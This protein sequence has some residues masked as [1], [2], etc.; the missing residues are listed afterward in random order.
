MAKKKGKKQKGE[1]EPPDPRLSAMKTIISKETNTRKEGEIT[2]NKAMMP[3]KRVNSNP[4]IYEMIP[5][6]KSLFPNSK[7]VDF[8]FEGVLDIPN[9]V[10]YKEEMDDVTV[11]LGDLPPLNMKKGANLKTSLSFLNS[12]EIDSR[13][14]DQL[15]KVESH[16][17]MHF[18]KT[19]VGK[20][21]FENILET[22]K[23]PLVD[24]QKRA[25]DEGGFGNTET[26]KRTARCCRLLI[27]IVFLLLILICGTLIGLVFAGIP[28]PYLSDLV[29]PPEPVS[30]ITD[31]TTIADVVESTTPLPESYI[32]VGSGINSGQLFFVAETELFVIQANVFKINNEAVDLSWEY[33][34]PPEHSKSKLLEDVFID[35]YD[36]LGYKIDIVTVDDINPGGSSWK[37]QVRPFGR[38]KYNLDIMKWYGFEYKG[39]ETQDEDYLEKTTKYVEEVFLSQQNA[40]VE[41]NAVHVGRS[42]IENVPKYI[43]KVGIRRPPSHIPAE[44]S[45]CSE[46]PICDK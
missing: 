10:Y 2:R 5:I 43:N 40:E 46:S 39:P 44:W 25:S 18:L 23:S 30:N 13:D 35:V 11:S 36:Y 15:D 32:G 9:Q 19:R 14:L 6:A 33:V 26:F 7:S 16:D 4:L 22:Y 38:P 37:V 8:G 21:N 27:L 42:F 12:T 29:F 1:E 20:E 3:L 31:T 24:I 41:Y 28:I 45:N 34:W 17:S